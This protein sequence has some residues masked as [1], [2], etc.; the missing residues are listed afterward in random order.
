[1]NQTNIFKT[2]E[3]SVAEIR[4]FN[5][6]RKSSIIPEKRSYTIL[7]NKDGKYMNLC[8]PLLNYPVYD[9]VPYSNNLS[10]GEDYGTMITLVSG[11]IKD[12]PCYILDVDMQKVLAR[13]TISY[14]DIISFVLQTSKFFPDRISIIEQMDFFSR[15]KY[16]KKYI[17]DKKDF[18]IFDN[19]MNGN[20]IQYK[21]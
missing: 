13:D 8:N 9:R 20:N 4:L 12:G 21:K 17:S 11:E 16:H 10:D 1:M 19:Y 3:L 14:E 7:F 5:E 6:E 2:K 18:E 15:M